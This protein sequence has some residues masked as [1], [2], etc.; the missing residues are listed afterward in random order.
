MKYESRDIVGIAGFSIVSGLIFIIASYSATFILAILGPIGI[1]TIYGIWFIGATLT[2]Y[3]I[4]KPGAALLG[5]LIGSHVELLFGSPYSIFLTYY[6][7]AQG[8]MSE[9]VFAFRKY[10]KWD[11]FTMALAGA[12]PTLAAFP[13]D[14]YIVPQYQY[15]QIPSLEVQMILL[16][17]YLASGAIIG[18]ILVKWLVD[19]AVKAGALRGWPVAKAN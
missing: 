4:R 3:I 18:G 6:G 2:G 17:L 10:K 14:Y 9:L 15:I 12:A 7:F 1:A 16:L 13:I 11:Y 8:I 5:E 19:R